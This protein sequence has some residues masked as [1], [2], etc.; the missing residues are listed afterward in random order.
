MCIARTSGRNLGAGKGWG[1]SRSMAEEG[2]REGL[3]RA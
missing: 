2:L 1:D 3:V